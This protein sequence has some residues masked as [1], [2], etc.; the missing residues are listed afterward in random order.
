VLVYESNLRG[1]TIWAA[2]T[3]YVLRVA[4]DGLRMAR[5][6][7]KLVNNDKPLYTLSFLI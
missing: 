5:K 3:D 2:R 7:V 6:A 1:E 4:G